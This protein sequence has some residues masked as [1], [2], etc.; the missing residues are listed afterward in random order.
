VRRNIKLKFQAHLQLVLGL[1]K[2]IERHDT[3]VV[4]ELHNDNLAVDALERFLVLGVCAIPL[5]DNI[6]RSQGQLTHSSNTGLA[7]ERH[8][9]RNDL[10]GSNLA[11]VLVFPELDAA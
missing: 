7:G 3:G 8:V 1:L 6:R 9:L 4:D 2:V 10:D 5:V 11:R